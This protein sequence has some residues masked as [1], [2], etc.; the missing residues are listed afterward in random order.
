MSVQV[1]YKKQTIFF[2]ILII[3]TLVLVEGLV[4][5]L[6]A[7]STPCSFIEN[8]LFSDY[9]Y[10]AKKDM[11]FEYIT[12]EYDFTT[13]LR[14]LEP[15]QHGN[16]INI[17]SDG[18]RGKEFN[19]KSDNYKI[20]ILGGST[21]FGHVSSSDDTTIP[22]FLEQKF[23]DDG[24]N[25]DVIN[26]GI[27]SGYS[28]TELYY[29]E[30]H[31]LKY[32]PDLII[33]YDGANDGT[34]AVRNISYKEFNENEFFVNEGLEKP[35]KS[36]KTTLSTFLTKIEYQTGL[37]LAQFISKS[38]EK[39]KMINNHYDKL[40]DFSSKTM[41]LENNWEQICS[42]ALENNFKS[43][44]IIQPVI[45]TS[46]RILSETEKN[47]T[48]QVNSE[49]LNNINL[50]KSKIQHCKTVL[51]LRNTFEGMDDVTIYFD[52]T[53]MTDFGNKIIANKIYEKIIPIILKDL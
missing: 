6:N 13:P 19:F 20:F 53:H 22:G 25:V 33:L 34:Q 2:I 5:N 49:F 39:S 52:A 40:S 51:D 18:F 41:R 24:I 36:K 28:R 15:N 10:F 21:I 45:G 11:C 30:N 3:L 46:D 32:S 47:I 44:N 23:R 7:V 38:L 35:P 31:L 26:A 43:I 4:R 14:L 17:N 8:E 48:V 29:L 50:N 12:I 27:P 37:G 1:S 9:D 42:I 16:Y